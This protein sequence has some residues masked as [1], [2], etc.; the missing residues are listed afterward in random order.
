MKLVSIGVGVLAAVF[1]TSSPALAEDMNHHNPANADAQAQKKPEAAATV[2][3]SINSTIYGVPELEKKTFSNAS[4]LKNYIKTATGKKYVEDLHAAKG[5]YLPDQEQN[6]SAD[7][8]AVTQQKSGFVVLGLD[9]NGNSFEGWDLSG[10]ELW[11]AELKNFDFSG[12][13][14]N[15]AKITR[16]VLSNVSFGGATARNMKLSRNNYITQEIG[17]MKY[18]TV[19]FTSCQEGAVTDLSGLHLSKSENA[20]GLN[21]GNALL[22]NADITITG[23][24]DINFEGA[25]LEGAKAYLKVTKS[26]FGYANLNGLT[27]ESGSEINDSD[28]LETTFDAGTTLRGVHITGKTILPAPLAAQ[29]NMQELDISAPAP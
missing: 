15:D 8:Q 1:M 17:G 12:A 24:S 16:S 11:N 3:V 4:D 9:G 18:N 10:I 6:Y 13:T 7:V 14:L 23:A 2:T 25:N 28:M 27:I 21:F 5:R 26:S 29:K 19:R 20:D 22:K